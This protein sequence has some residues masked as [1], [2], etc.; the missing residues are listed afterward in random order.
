[1]NVMVFDVPAE[2]GGG[3]SVLNDFYNEVVEY[4]DKKIN[5]IFVVSKPNLKEK[6]NIKVLQY[7]WIKKSW[8]HRYFFDNILAPRIIKKYN[9]DRIFSLQNVIVPYTK[10]KQI[11]YVHNSLPFVDHRFSLIKSPLLW[12]YQNIIS[13][14]IRKSIVL[15]DKV[16]AQTEWMK[17]EFVAE[18]GVKENKIEV[19][20][21]KINVKVN[22]EF[23]P[24]RE[25]LTTFFYPASGVVFKNHKIVVDACKLLTKNNIK[26]NVIFT[27]KGDENNEI[28]KIKKEV[29]THKLNISFKG[30]LKRE[31]VFELYSKTVL[32]FPSFVESSPLPLTEALLHKCII[33]ASNCSFSKEILASYKN[34]YYFDPFNANELERLMQK[35]VENIIGYEN[36][37]FMISSNVNSIIDVV[38][39]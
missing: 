22:K 38:M 36:Q 15:A 20:P 14:Q 30:S 10:T 33:L 25:S 24:N 5:W 7:P 8:G 35:V 26:Y 2:S 34:A 9:V 19:I 23:E 17:N 29:E 11:L 16:I 12:I 37:S 39:E 27:L 18:T 4:N 31:E 1:M 3:L 21:P 28:S 32:L 6:D 13:K